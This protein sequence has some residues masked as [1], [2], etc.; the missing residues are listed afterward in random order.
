M[1]NLFKT[2]EP[3]K[4]D[5]PAELPDEQDLAKARRRRV[6]REKNTSGVESTILSDGGR[7]T[8]GG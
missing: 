8:L 6:A 2:P 4:I 1:T 3:P 7:E 5:P